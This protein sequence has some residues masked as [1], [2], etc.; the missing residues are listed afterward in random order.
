M[1][2][3]VGA[4]TLAIALVRAVASWLVPTRAGRSES[5][6]DVP[7]GNEQRAPTIPSEPRAPDAQDACLPAE[8]PRQGRLAASNG[9]SAKPALPPN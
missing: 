5:L 7:G 2:L 9:A 1:S 3:R 8:R 4:Q 6:L